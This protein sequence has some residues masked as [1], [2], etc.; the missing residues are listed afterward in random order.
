MCG[1]VGNATSTA[2]NE[3]ISPAALAAAL[4]MIVVG[5]G[6][7]LIYGHGKKQAWRPHQTFVVHDRNQP[8]AD[9]VELI[10]PPFT[11]QDEPSRVEFEDVPLRTLQG[12]HSNGLSDTLNTSLL[13]SEQ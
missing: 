2:L 12:G 11:E 6:L 9:A 5:I 7:I 8:V 1:T 3:P 13:E 4:V 10:E